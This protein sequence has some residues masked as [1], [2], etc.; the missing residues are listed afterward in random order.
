[1]INLI[2]KEEKKKV[3]RDSY[4]KLVILFLVMLSTAILIAFVVILPSYFLSSVKNSI[5]NVKL[6]M[7]K[8]EPMP[9]PDQQTLIVIKNLNNK[10]TLIENAE[11]NKFTISRKVIN[12]IVLKKMPDIKITDISYENDPLKGKKISIEGNA[13]SREVLLLFRLAL[14]NDNNFKQV[15]LPISNFVK[16]SNIQFYL[17]LIPS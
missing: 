7:Q 6:E 17:S 11:N 1:M 2:P 9:P 15:D 5:I 16:G 4:Y 14:E 8:S 3:I 13:P 12:A 10:L